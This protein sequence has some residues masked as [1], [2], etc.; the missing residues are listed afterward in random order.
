MGSVDMGWMPKFSSV[1]SNLCSSSRGTVLP[2]SRSKVQEHITHNTLRACGLSKKKGYDGWN[3]FGN[4]LGENV[5]QRVSLVSC[6][7]PIGQLSRYQLGQWEIKIL[8]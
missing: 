2:H 5:K 8:I 4:A 1:D 3:G 6:N 7:Q